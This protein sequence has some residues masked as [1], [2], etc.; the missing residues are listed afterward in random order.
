M[1]KHD[2]IFRVINI[3]MWSLG[4]DNGRMTGFEHLLKSYNVADQLDEIASSDPPAYLRR[5]FAEGISAPALSLA[6]IQQLA[7]CG[8]V[9][10]SILNDRE[11]ESIEPELIADWRAH[12]AP[13]FARLKQSA[14]A[15]LHRALET[16]RTEDR[17]A[18]GELET[19]ELRLAPA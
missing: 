13:A 8:M 19:L 9:L 14:A 12:S 18:A 2:Q 11:Y 6:R 3:P 15:A 10:D 16:L 17:D 1:I 7:V 5:C 4:A